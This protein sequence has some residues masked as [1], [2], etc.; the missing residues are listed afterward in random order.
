MRFSG[1]VVL[2]LLLVTLFIES[3]THGQV[4]DALGPNELVCIAV[5]K[6]ECSQRLPRAACTFKDGDRIYGCACGGPALAPSLDRT[7][8]ATMRVHQL[9]LACLASHGQ[10]DLQLEREQNTRNP[11]MQMQYFRLRSGSSFCAVDA[12]H[13]TATSYQFT[14]LCALSALQPQ[15]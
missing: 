4:V 7:K 11:N 9:T 1:V 6:D 5:L 2:G 13:L 8:Q 3:Q 14:I 15:R 12:P 10:R